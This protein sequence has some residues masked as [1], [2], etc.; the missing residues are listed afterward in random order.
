MSGVQALKERLSRRD[1]T[2]SV[3]GLGY[4]GVPEHRAS[5]PVQ[6][7]IAAHRFEAT[8][9][10]DRLSEP[11]AV[12]VCRGSG[13]SPGSGSRRR[14]APCIDGPPAFPSPRRSGGCSRATRARRREEVT[15]GEA[16]LRTPVLRARTTR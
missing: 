10:L 4:V 9:E 12:I 11:D 1:Y 13:T 3:I 7:L 2:V 15:T 6:A 16:D 5:P 8:A 14:I